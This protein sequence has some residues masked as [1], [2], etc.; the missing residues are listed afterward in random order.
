MSNGDKPADKDARVLNNFSRPKIN[1]DAY[2]PHNT[3][4]FHRIEKATSKIL[5]TPDVLDKRG[6][7]KAQVLRVEPA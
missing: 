1:A 3:D 6:P 5:Y 7:F 2:D 4:F